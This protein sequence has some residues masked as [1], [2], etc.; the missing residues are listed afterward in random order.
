MSKSIAQGLAIVEQGVPFTAA[1][2]Q[3]FVRLAV[4]YGGF[5]ILPV[6]SS[7]YRDWFFY[8]FFNQYDSL[9]TANAFQAILNHLEARASQNE[10]N[11][12]LAVFR[13]VG[14]RG[15]GLLPDQIL[16]DLANS[17]CQFVEIS[18]G[19]WRVTAGVDALF[20]TSRSSTALPAPVL[21]PEDAPFEPLEA[22]RSCLNLS[23]RADWLRC[24][25]WL[26]AAFRPYGPY[27]FLILQGPPGSGKT[28]AARILR[29]LIDPSVTPLSP[30]PSSVRDL[31]T[32]ARHNWVL[33]FDHISTLSP[34]LT[35][36][37]CRLSSG[38]GAAVRETPRAAP[39]PLLQSYKRPVLLTVTDRWSC[40][41][42]LADRA[43]TVTLP[44]V[45][46]RRTEADL[47]TAFSE[48]RPGIL[49][50]LCSAVGTALSRQPQTNLP[51][52]R[53]ADALAW[54]IAASPAL[55]C[56]EEEMRQAFP[57]PSPPHPMVEAVSSLLEQRRHFTGTATQL[58]DLL[59]PALSCQL[60]K[61]LSQQLR[62]CTLTLAD[63]G[64]EVRF[65]R[66]HGGRKVIE[67]RPDR[68]VASREKAPPDATPDFDLTPQPTETEEL[69]AS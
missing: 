40:P 17:D 30:T 55:G 6:R 24:L 9:P 62:S 38:I 25:A 58:M 10:V 69:I 31:L 21:A 15:P 56:T 68:G 46:C 16:L 23:G 7:A 3:A 61:G 43:I 51:G 8:R 57:P 27:P 13:R 1:D 53:C 52:G 45:C 49:G 39:E 48:A 36:A 5:Y 41:A 54:A 22:L 2:G 4:P 33:A 59:G 66:L 18:P 64:I 67:L 29:F 12:R 65:R 28:L 20:Q 60:P 42:D 26:L 37:L 34:Q 14:A 32:L 11:E 44:P 19:S 50:A 35:D 47:L 63:S